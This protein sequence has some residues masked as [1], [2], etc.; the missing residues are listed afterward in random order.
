MAPQYLIWTSDVSLFLLTGAQ[1]QL[2][3]AV[4]SNASEQTETALAMEAELAATRDQ[5]EAVLTQHREAV[6][7]AA[8]LEAEL[9]S[10]RAQLAESEAAAAQLLVAE[11][12]VQ[13]TTAEAEELKVCGAVRYTSINHVCNTHNLVV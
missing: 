8:A 6:E 12:A 2:A 7:K 1:Q 3:D 9:A 11:Q 10:A 4:P 13:A 5:L